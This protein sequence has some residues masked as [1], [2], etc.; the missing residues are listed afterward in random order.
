MK[1]KLVVLLLVLCSVS[2]GAANGVGANAIAKIT[3]DEGLSDKETIVSGEKEAVENIQ[4]TFVYNEN[5]LYTIYSRVN[6]ITTIMFQ[7]GEEITYIAGGDTARWTVDQAETGSEVGKRK[8]IYIK[9]F[10]VGIKTN[11]VI[12]TNKRNYQFTLYSAKEWYNP[13][14]K[15]LYP[16]EEKLAYE[17]KE[18]S[19]E[20]VNIASLTD[21]NYNYSIADN[22]LFK[23]IKFKPS[24]VFDDGLKT[25]IVLPE[26][27]QEMP[28][29]FIYENNELQLANFRVKDQ[30]IIVDRLF[31]C[32]KLVLGKE[33]V[34]L[35]K[36][37]NKNTTPSNEEN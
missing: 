19:F 2:Y 23:R 31:D 24:Q 30:Y 25:Y 5:S 7:P 36:Y 10:S 37:Y 14:V 28:A 6:N 26:K 29:L 34:T 17:R 9:P 20:P 35:T 22:K 1:K 16:N 3:S 13:V 4:A 21:L 27:T 11:L 32:G 8:C 15:F 12:N 33:E 18:S